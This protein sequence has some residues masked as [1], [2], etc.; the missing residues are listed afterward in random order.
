M[1]VDILI[2]S[3]A[4]PDVLKR[5]INTFRKHIKTSHTLRYV[6]LEDKVDDKERQR[7]GRKWLNKNRNL[8][9][10]IHFAEKRMGPGFFFA[11]V[12]KLCKTDYFFHLE[13][14]NEFTFDIEI[15]PVVEVMKNNEYIT[16]VVLRRGITDSRNHP[17][18]VVIDG[19]KLTEMDIFSVAT[20]V[21]NTKSV[22]EI[23]N[24]VGWKRQLR[25]VWILGPAAKELGFKKYTLGFNKNKPHYEHIG[26]K[27]GYRKGGWK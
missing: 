12:V 18:N 27:K 7:A 15:D 19:L 10:E 9:D 1:N 17:T 20:G 23:I 21:F 3:C 5:S 6:I 26:P 2:N 4:R 8:F 13:D 25:E 22:K 16:E 14:D 24:K 11:P